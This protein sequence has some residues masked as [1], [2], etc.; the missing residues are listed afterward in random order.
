MIHSKRKW[1]VAAAIILLIVAVIVGT[2]AMGSG[3][4][5]P[6]V[7]NGYVA[8][9]RIDGEI[10]GGPPT[11]NVF[12]SNG[13]SSEQVMSELESARKD[14]NAKAILLR[15]NS[16]GGSTGATQE[17]S[18]EL[19]KIKNSGKPIVVSMGDACASAGY[20]IASKGDYIFANPATLTGS[21]GV[22][23]DYTTVE[24]LAEKL[25]VKEE[26]IKSG[27]YKDMLSMFRPMTPEERTMI[28][29]MVDDIYGQFVTTVAEGRHMDI[30]KVKAIADGRV[31]TG[32][33]AQALGLVDAMGNY[34]DALGYAGGL[35]GMNEDVPTHS[36]EEKLYLR[37]LLSAN[38][39][40]FAKIIGK[41]MATEMKSIT[42]LDQQP[43]VK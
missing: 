18:E 36:Y 10:Y 30:N 38:A 20:W 29:G 16:P 23:I 7:R 11:G 22:Y 25:G 41:N 13:T 2:E 19:D 42:S 9:I 26:K 32:R 17:I 12:S 40:S 35:V 33:Q 1:V 14:V 5:L 4:S 3:K 15:I 28:Q 21:I 39:E 43:V 31:I 6:K 24:G 37:N 34:Y 8:V 27:L